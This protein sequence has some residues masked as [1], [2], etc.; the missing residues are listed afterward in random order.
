MPTQQANQVIL[1]IVT[2]L[3]GPQEVRERLM[4]LGFKTGTPVCILSSDDEFRIFKVRGIR[5]RLHRFIAE[6]IRIE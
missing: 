4:K 5:I 2:A 6:Q 3:G 1:K